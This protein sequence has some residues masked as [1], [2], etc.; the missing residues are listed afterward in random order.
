VPIIRAGPV[1]TGNQW[2][3]LSLKGNT[4]YIDLKDYYIDQ[5]DSI[6]GIL[7]GLV[8]PPMRVVMA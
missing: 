7:V 2:K 4:A 6:M 8:Q 3:F 1:T 5:V